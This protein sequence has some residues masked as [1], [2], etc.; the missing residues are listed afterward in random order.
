MQ[1]EIQKLKCFDKLI[2]ELG[3]LRNTVQ[4]LSK[5]LKV[6]G[7]DAKTEKEAKQIL[8]T[9]HT[10]RQIGFKEHILKY[11]KQLSAIQ[12]DEQP[13]ICCSDVI[14]SCFGKFKFK[15]QNSNPQFNTQFQYCIANFGQR[16]NT[17]QIKDAL[18]FISVNDLKNKPKNRKNNDPNIRGK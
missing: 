5:L 6:K 12:K 15:K 18:E 10:K 8:E 17:Q 13:L 2:T 4:K 1:S 3:E 9:L 16:Y 11:F 14:E 7:F